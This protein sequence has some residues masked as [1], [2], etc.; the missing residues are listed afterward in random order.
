MGIK[1]E[2]INGKVE[3]LDNAKCWYPICNEA[4]VVVSRFRCV[5]INSHQASKITEIVILFS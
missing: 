4:F 5:L 1:I 2:Y 3:T